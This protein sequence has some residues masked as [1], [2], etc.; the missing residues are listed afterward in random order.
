MSVFVG[1]QRR[2]RRDYVSSSAECFIRDFQ[3]VHFLLVTQLG[4]DRSDV[5]KVLPTGIADWII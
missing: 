1:P 2:Y 5:L 3:P 4:H